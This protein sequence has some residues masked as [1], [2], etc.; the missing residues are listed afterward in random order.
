MAPSSTTLSKQERCRICGHTQRQT[1]IPNQLWVRDQIDHER[2]AHKFKH[3]FEKNK[4]LRTSLD[5]FFL[6]FRVSGLLCFSGFREFRVIAFQFHSSSLLILADL[7][8]RLAAPYS[9]ALSY[10]LA[11][12]DFGLCPFPA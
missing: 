12:E 5:G 4:E 9:L 7:G 6:A 11:V 10:R 1:T 3:G 8:Y 2:G